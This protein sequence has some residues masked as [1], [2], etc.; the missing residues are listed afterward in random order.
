MKKR[1]FYVLSLAIIVL[2]IVPVAKVYAAETKFEWV[3]QEG[4]LEEDGDFWTWGYN[5]GQI[6]DAGYSGE[7]KKIMRGVKK[8]IVT[9][10]AKKRGWDIDKSVKAAQHFQAEFFRKWAKKMELKKRIRRK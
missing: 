2:N 6:E 9:E 7:T 1:L 3:N 10:Y 8:V 4:A 5:C